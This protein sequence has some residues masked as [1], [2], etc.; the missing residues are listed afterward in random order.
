[1]SVRD[2]AHMAARVWRGM[3]GLDAYERYLAH[4]L[5]V[6][7]ELPAP[8]KAQFYRDKWDHESHSPT[9]RCC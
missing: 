6:H 3:N 5:H 1:M 4:H 7:P 9:A 8:T 2:V